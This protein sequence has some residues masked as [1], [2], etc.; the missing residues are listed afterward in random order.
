ME[1]NLVLSIHPIDFMSMSDNSSNWTSCMNWTD[2]GD[3]RAGTVEMM[4]SDNVIVAYLES[5]RTPFIV[6]EHEIPNKKW[7]TLIICSD[8]GIVNVKG[9]P[10][11]SDEL[12]QMCCEWLAQLMKDNMG[13][14]MVQQEG[15][16]DDYF[17]FSTEKMYND[18]CDEKVTRFCYAPKDV[19]KDYPIRICY[20]GQWRCVCCGTDYMGIDDDYD[21]GEGDA[22]SSWVVCND[23][24]SVRLQHR[25]CICGRLINHMEEAVMDGEY[26]CSDHIDEY[27]AWDPI[28]NR[29]VNLDDCAK[30]TA[31]KNE[32]EYTIMT[33]MDGVTD[34]LNKY[35]LEDHTYFKKQ[36][37]EHY[38]VNFSDLTEEGWNLFRD[39]GEIDF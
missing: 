26:Y 27:G 34:N 30:V 13:I 25:C 11:Q 7:R 21:D 6:E 37:R 8:E 18:F 20:S 3:Y 14:E 36:G 1:G 28:N 2:R 5:V 15:D 9:Y 22:V 31:I 29:Y 33:D 32:Y 4:N 35:I 19:V 23:C 38:L 39:F 10:Y 12:A 24:G 16:Y 17:D